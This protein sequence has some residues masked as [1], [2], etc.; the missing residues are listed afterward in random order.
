MCLSENSLQQPVDNN[1]QSNQR[2]VALANDNPKKSTADAKMRIKKNQ[3][4]LNFALVKSL[5]M[6]L[7]KL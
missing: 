1:L 5:R 7:I 2:N 6:K 4:Q 3:Q